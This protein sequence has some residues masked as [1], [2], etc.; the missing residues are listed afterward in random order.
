MGGKQTR[1]EV[2]QRAEDGQPDFGFG[3]GGPNSLGQ[4]TTPR[5]RVLEK[6]VGASRTRRTKK[7]LSKNSRD[8]ISM[9]MDCLDCQWFEVNGNEGWE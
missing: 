1:G 9:E 6:Q 4:Y 8:S 5:G 3:G 2:R 7:E